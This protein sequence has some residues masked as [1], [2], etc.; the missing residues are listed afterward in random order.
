SGVL[1]AILVPEGEVV[2]IGTRIALVGTVDE[3]LPD[4]PS[5]PGQ[6][7]GVRQR[8]AEI[9]SQRSP[10]SSVANG[11]WV[12]F[13][14]ILLIMTILGLILLVNHIGSAFLLIAVA[15][16]LYGCF[17]LVGMT[18]KKTR[19]KEGGSGKELS[20]MLRFH[21]GIAAAIF[22]IGMSIIQLLNGLIYIKVLPFEVANQISWFGDSSVLIG[23]LYW[24]ALWV[25]RV[26]KRRVW[27]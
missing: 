27:S 1:R 15:I 10:F 16:F 19:E 6:M 17:V 4:T 20:R 25:I 3:P 7:V 2:S 14:G 26:R 24:L 12:L 9:T 13:N 5:L 23:G 21:R 22:L 18:G 8:C 11:W